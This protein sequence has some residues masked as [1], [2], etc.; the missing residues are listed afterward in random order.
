M[1]LFVWG[2]IIAWFVV[3][4]LIN[5]T[6]FYV[7]FIA[8]FRFYVGVANQVLATATFWFYWPLAT[9][10]ALLPTVVFRT[11]RL[12]LDPHLVDDVRL[13]M[14]A[15]GKKLFKRFRFKRSSL[16]R[17]GTVTRTGYAFAHE[18][19]FGRII[20]SGV[21]FRGMRQDLVEEERR[22]RLT[23]IGSRPPSGSTTPVTVKKPL[24]PSAAFHEAETAGT[25]ETT[26]NEK[27]DVTAETTIEHVTDVDIHSTDQSA[28]ELE[29]EDPGVK[30]DLGTKDEL[31]VKDDLGVKD[32]DP[33]AKEDV[34]EFQENL[35]GTV[36]LSGSPE[37]DIPLQEKSAS[38]EGTNL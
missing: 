15:D 21:G 1:H 22:K 23:T 6:A 13:K 26:P 18:E 14:K 5:S 9:V 16:H 12:D 28:T 27:V 8:L 32:D 31:S 4:P 29:K 35:P 3:V 10:I 11:I 34:K 30:E 24:E 2:S 33:G 20:E 17:K 37:P 38:Y 19:G 7:G 36:P 25:V